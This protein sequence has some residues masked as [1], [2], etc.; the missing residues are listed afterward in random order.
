MSLLS[1][2]RQAVTSLNPAEVREMAEQRVSIRLVAAHATSYTTMAGW[3]MPES[4]S[5]AKR[6][7]ASRMIR[8]TSASV[9]G[10]N[11]SSADPR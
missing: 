10:K 9:S 7:D 4:I 8:Q 1:Q 11:T 3:L 2:L 6:A 5:A